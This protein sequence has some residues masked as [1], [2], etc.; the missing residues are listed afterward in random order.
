MPLKQWPESFQFITIDLFHH[1]AQE[2]LLCLSNFYSHYTQIFTFMMYQS[3]KSYFFKNLFSVHQQLR[4]KPADTSE[5]NQPYLSIASRSIF[6]HCRFLYTRIA[7]TLLLSLLT[8]YSQAQQFSWARHVIGNYSNTRIQVLPNGDYFVAGENTG[9]LQI[10]PFLNCGAGGTDVFLAEFD[11][12]TGEIE[13]LKRLAGPSDDKIGDITISDNH[14][15]I[16]GSFREQIIIDQFRNNNPDAPCTSFL[17]ETL[18]S[19][20][21]SDIFF[22][23]YYIGTGSLSFA[24]S[25]GGPKDD[26]AHG[27]KVTGTSTNGSILLTGSFKK[28]ASFYSVDAY[29][30]VLKT[31]LVKG[32]NEGMYRDGF[33]ANYRI[34]KDA[35]D[36]LLLSIQWAKRLGISPGDDYGTAVDIDHNGNVYVTGGFTHSLTFA[37]PQNI[38]WTHLVTPAPQGIGYSDVFIAKYSA[39]GNYLWANQ[40]GGNSADGGE[41]IVVDGA[42][43]I[44][45]A[46]YYFSSNMAFYRNTQYTKTPLITAAPGVGSEGFLAKYKPNGVVEWV[47]TLTG[48]QDDRLTSVAKD[49]NGNLIVTGYFTGSATAYT[50]KGNQVLNSTGGTVDKDLVVINFKPDG[51][52]T[53]KL[54]GGGATPNMAHAVGIDQNNGVYISGYTGANASFASHKLTNSGSFV[55]KVTPPFGKATAR[56]EGVEAEEIAKEFTNHMQLQA[57]PIPASTQLTLGFI[58]SAS[59]FTTISLFDVK[60]SL[61]AVL[62][63]EQAEAGKAY[64]LTLD[65][66]QYTPGIYIVKSNSLTSEGYTKIVIV[67]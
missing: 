11:G 64:Q 51:G 10:G 38:Y 37:A 28:E 48:S 36:D 45:V 19:N 49:K 2:S 24:R 53:W 31:I 33:L 18:Y 3:P 5:K 17:A 32:E 27:I 35:Q 47:N 65:V 57:Y 29:D 34:T 25:V 16:T 44:Y 39:S 42:G 62:F 52:I 22:A 26:Q 55:V 59:E 9:D 40:A 60:G 63:Q 67:K 14:V 56:A 66:S 15:Y 30:K 7:L 50:N 20:G 54:V 41:D 21:G 1:L 4:Y 58:P 46:G 13:K 12:K 6:L 61:K 23:R 43:N 8:F